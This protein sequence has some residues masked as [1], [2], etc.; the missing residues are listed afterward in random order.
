MSEYSDLM[1]CDVKK[2]SSYQLYYFK[3]VVHIHNKWWSD[4]LS[5]IP[6]FVRDIDNSL[7]VLDSFILS[8]PFC[9]I[10]HR[11]KIA[12]DTKKSIWLL[13]FIKSMVEYRQRERNISLFHQ[14]LE[15]CR[16]NNNTKNIINNEMIGHISI[17]W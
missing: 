7:D 15:N 3:F 8:M 9:A 12:K 13:S 5:R 16:K 11:S 4:F 2:Y 10:K 1:N 17:H 14:R 6:D